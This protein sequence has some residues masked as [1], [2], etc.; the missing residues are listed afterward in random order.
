M[1]ITAITAII[2][3]DAM[4]NN[5]RVKEK[6]ITIQL[7]VVTAKKIQDLFK[8]GDS[9]DAVINRLLNG[10]KPEEK[11]EPHGDQKNEPTRVGDH[12]KE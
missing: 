12:K 8:F 6:T 11:G 9:Y 1:T 2:V 5:E 7:K 4:T 3:I 10:N